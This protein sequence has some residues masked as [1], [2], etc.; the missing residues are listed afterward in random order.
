[1][2]PIHSGSNWLIV[3]MLKLPQTRQG[4]RPRWSFTTW[5]WKICS[6]TKRQSEMFW[7]FSETVYGRNLPLFTLPEWH[8]L[9]MSANDFLWIQGTK[10]GNSLF[11]P[12]SFTTSK[13]HSAF[14]WLVPALVAVHGLPQDSGRDNLR[15]LPVVSDKACRESGL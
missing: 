9:P 6:Q 14:S 7:T 3:C 12:T 5:M 15:R 4:S 13:H 2:R 8:L 11:S 10:K 1:M